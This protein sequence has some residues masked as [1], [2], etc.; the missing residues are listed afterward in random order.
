[1]ANRWSFP[2]N[3]GGEFDGWKDA[4]IEHFS[5]EPYSTLAREVIQNSLDARANRKRPVRVFFDLLKVPVRDFPDRNGLKGSVERALEQARALDGDEPVAFLENA[6]SLL[7]KRILCLRMADTNTKGLRGPCKLPN[8]FFAFVKAKGQSVKASDTAGGSYGIGKNAPFASSELRTILVSTNYKEKGKWVELAQGKSILMSHDDPDGDRTN[9]TGY[10][11][12][13]NDWTPISPATSIPEW[14][15]RRDQFGNDRARQ[16]TTVF[17]A[18]FRERKHWQTLL[19]ASVITNYFS[20]I[21]DGR[22]AVSIHG[23][24]YEVTSKTLKKW[25][26]NTGVRNAATV[27]GQ[28]DELELANHM[29]R[30]L[31]HKDAKEETSQLKHLGL[32]RV[33]LLVQEGLP[34]RVGIL[35]NGMKVT[36]RL[37]RLVQFPGY[38]D[39]VA[40]VD[41]LDPKGNQLLRKMENP[42]HNEFEPDRLP[43]PKEVEKGRA[44]LGRLAAF[45][46]SVLKKHA[47]V[48]RGETTQLDELSEFFQD[49]DKEESVPQAKGEV[50]LAGSIVILAKEPKRKAESLPN[51]DGDGD[52]D[53]DQGRERDGDPRGRVK[54]GGPK[55]KGGGPGKSRSVIPLKD[56]RCIVLDATRREIFFTP[57]SSG[58]A[59]LLLQDAGADA[60]YPLPVRS[61]KGG[62]KVHDGK[63]Q[64]LRLDADKRRRITV[65]LDEEFSG[66]VR[67]V[68]HAV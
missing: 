34:Q 32:C 25:F 37:K 49:P 45:V 28:E 18:G 66:A 20:A 2:K 4:G 8:P 44:E 21:Y 64:Q 52:D 46:R 39:F 22:L 51:S 65:T 3:S 59:D 23:E 42:A 48:E 41:C 6:L 14:M 11:G 60:V 26:A 62:G 29:T 57:T 68:A 13:T 31:W 36:H 43:N 1:M 56:I 63:I 38:S 5:G 55:A 58:K 47:R 17:V 30:C 27:E 61:V 10:Y 7:S 12:R 19:L 16:G 35:R 67:V 40:V 50:N 9:G 15:R 33:R 53:G 24:N 54:R